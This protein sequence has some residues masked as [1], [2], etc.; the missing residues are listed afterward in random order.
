M[1]ELGSNPAWKDVQ[2]GTAKENPSIVGYNY[3]YSDNIP[4][5]ESLGVGSSGSFGQLFT[6]LRATGSYVKA[7][8]VGDRPLGNAYFLNSGGTCTAPDGSAQPRMNYVNNVSDGLL[9]GV[10]S[11][12]GGLN[13]SYLFSAMTSD[14]TP[15]CS[16][17]SC[18]TTNG[19]KFG[20]LTPDLSPDFSSKLCQQVDPSNCMPNEPKVRESYTNYS[21]SALPTILAAVGILLLT[22]SGK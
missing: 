4:K 20:F 11:D 22:F 14:G 8:T 1:A 17:Y 18:Q 13:P 7:M 12:I 10:I 21:L 3:S 2:N 16:C 19:P 5:P 9:T 6:N 15:A